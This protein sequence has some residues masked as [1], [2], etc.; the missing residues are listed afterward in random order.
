MKGDEASAA[1]GAEIQ[2]EPEA[3]LGEAE[4]LLRAVLD[5]LPVSVCRY[6]R[7][8]IFRF[9][10]GKGLEVSGGVRPGELLGKSVY[11]LY[12]GS[13]GAAEAIRQAIEGK[14]SH[15]VTEAHG[16]TWETWFA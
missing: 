5:N 6:D 14:G 8:G 4:L 2:N 13:P 11:E 15:A 3:E 1:A 16:L 9:H 7:E 10:D 12:A